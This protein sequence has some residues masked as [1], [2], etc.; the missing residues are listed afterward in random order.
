MWYFTGLLHH[1]PVVDL[2]P[3]DDTLPQF[4]AAT[5][6]HLCLHRRGGCLALPQNVLRC[7]S[8]ALQGL[9]SAEVLLLKGDAHLHLPLHHQDTGGAPCCLLSVQTGIQGLLLEQPAASPHH[10]QIVVAM[11]GVPLVRR[12]ALKPPRLPLTSGDNSPLHTVANQSAE[13]PTLQSHATTRGKERAMR[14]IHI[15]FFFFA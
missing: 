2:H 11:L 1:H 3:P 8:G 12:D 15:D 6:P 9:P 13:C 5:V 7:P 10:L 4:S 14:L